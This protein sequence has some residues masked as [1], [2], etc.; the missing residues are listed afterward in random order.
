MTLP[1]LCISLRGDRHPQNLSSDGTSYFKRQ[2]LLQSGD[3]NGESLQEEGRPMGA[4]WTLGWG[5]PASPEE[6]G[7]LGG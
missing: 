1:G 2:Q 6:P 3:K 4:E 7:P 5:W